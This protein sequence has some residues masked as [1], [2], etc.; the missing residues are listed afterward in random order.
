M[1]L[2]ISYSGLFGG[3]ERQLVEVA[4]ALPG[5]CGLAC[6]EG[7]LAQA[8]EEAGLRVFPSAARSLRVRGGL[9]R[10]AAAVANLSG[11]AWR[12]S[13]RASTRRNSKVTIAPPTPRRSWS[14]ARS[15]GGSGLTWRSKRWRTSDE[16]IQTCG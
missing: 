16:T 7:A 11:H 9:R 6:P 1:I 2:F 3:A 4:T 14:S 15:S 10:R 13:T 5:E 8:A 12:S